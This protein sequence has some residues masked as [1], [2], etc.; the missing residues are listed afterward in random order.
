MRQKAMPGEDPETLRPP[1][2]VAPLILKLLSPGCSR[3]G[4]LLTFK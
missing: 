2:A 1:A 4:E 3:N